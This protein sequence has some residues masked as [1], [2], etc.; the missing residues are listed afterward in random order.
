M[1][2]RLREFRRA[3][4]L[5]QYELGRL[6]GSYQ[7]RV[8]LLEHGYLKPIDEEKLRISRVLGVSADAVFPQSRRP[9]ATTTP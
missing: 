9:E 2:S 1:K 7:H 8:W 4:G 3:A 5:S 6:I